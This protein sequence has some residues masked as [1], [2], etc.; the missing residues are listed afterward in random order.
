M[1]WPELVAISR[2]YLDR[3]KRLF[4]GKAD[5]LHSC[6]E[7]CGSLAAFSQR[8]SQEIPRNFF[9]V[10]HEKK[11]R[12]DFAV[13]SAILLIVLI[14]GIV[15]IVINSN[16]NPKYT[17]VDNF[18]GKDI[19]TNVGPGGN[20]SYFQLPDPTLGYVNYGTHANL[21]KIVDGTKLRI[22]MGA[23]KPGPRNAIRLERNALFDS[24]LVVFDVEH[25]P[26]DISSWPAFWSL[27]ITNLDD[28]WALYGEIDILEQINDSKFNSCTLH[29]NAPPG[30]TPCT[31]DP[32]LDF[33]TDNCFAS[34]GPKTCGFESKDYCP[35]DGCSKDMAPGTFGS[36]LN[37]SGGGTF[38]MQLTQDGRVT[39]WLWK[40]SETVPDFVNA[41]TDD[42]VCENVIRF[43]KC[44]GSF[45]RQQL[46]IN[47]TLCGGWAGRNCCNGTG[48]QWTDDAGCR[49]YV[50]SHDLDD[51]YWLIRSLQFYNFN[52]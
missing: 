33:K 21:L 22:D 51:S 45:S 13:S 42:F 47:T 18:T 2:F 11:T 50:D 24:G 7:L 23:N 32:A 48:D 49:A 12:M 31:M 37:D 1:R 8:F 4:H 43:S 44:S 17:L 6:P 38:A 16:H 5:A 3:I 25:I 35:Y 46:I 10:I 29:T 19:G 26:A 20:F 14:L 52:Y 9:L 36:S 34:S 30:G 27:G 41:T 39:V 40:H 15:L 28:F